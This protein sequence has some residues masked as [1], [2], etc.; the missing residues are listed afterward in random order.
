MSDDDNEYEDDD[1]E[2]DFD[3]D[4]QFILLIKVD[5]VP[6]TQYKFKV[7]AYEFFHGTGKIFPVWSKEVG[8]ICVL[9]FFLSFCLVRRVVGGLYFLGAVCHISWS[10]WIV[11]SFH[12]FQVVF[13]LD[14]TPKF[15]VPP[16]VYEKV[17]V[18]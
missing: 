7:A 8:M 13:V 6:C 2:E 4:V 9:S 3:E 1:D 14:Y 10:M 12:S 11:Y 5:L 15:I 16:I 18:I 17:N